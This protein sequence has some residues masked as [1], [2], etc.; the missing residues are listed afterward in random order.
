MNVISAKDWDLIVAVCHYSYQTDLYPSIRNEAYKAAWNFTD[1]YG[2]LGYIPPQGYDWSGFRDSSA[3]SSA[4]SAEAIRK[5]L[6]KHNIKE[7][8]VK[9]LY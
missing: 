9:R 4:K 1:A 6:Q 2:E 8:V 3:Q 5:I 7:F